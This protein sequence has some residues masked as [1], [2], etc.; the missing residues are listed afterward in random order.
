MIMKKLFVAFAGVVIFGSCSE[1]TVEKTA[2]EKE[3]T[4]TQ[5]KQEIPDVTPTKLL[6]MEVGGMSCEM[7]CGSAIRKGLLATGAVERVKFD[8]KMGRD[9]NTAEISFDDSKISEEGIKKIVSELNDKQ[10]NI[11]KTSVDD[12][13]KETTKQS[14]NS[15][16]GHTG[17]TTKTESSF[18][19]MEQNSFGIEAP[20]VIDLLLSAI[21]RR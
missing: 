3:T 2:E 5:E 11:G 19:K 17:N 4:V 7:G 10:F 1:T 9:L 8:F 13:T 16:S 21:L 6:T 20:N 12:Y 15:D 14:S 18:S